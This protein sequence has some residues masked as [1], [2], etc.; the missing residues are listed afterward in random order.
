MAIVYK[1]NINGRLTIIGDKE[2]DLFE[3]P[4]KPDALIEKSFVL[5]T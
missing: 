1:V 5:D 4:S 2:S 3:G